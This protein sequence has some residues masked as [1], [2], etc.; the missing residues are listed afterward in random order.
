MNVI[1]KSSILGLAILSVLS[2]GCSSDDEDSDEYGNWV[3]SSSFDG[4]SRGNAASFT[5]G[6]KGYLVTGYDGDDY[7]SDTWEYNSEGDYWIQKADFPGTAR[8]GAV[9]F[10]IDGKGYI[11]TGYD[12]TDELKDFWEYNPDTNQ[13]TQK[14]D[15]A[16]TAR[17]GAIGFSVN[18]Y[19]YIGTG[20]DGSEQKDFYKYDASTD[21]WEQ[22]VGFGGQKRQNASVFVIDD[23]AYIG[24]GIHNGSVEY[25]FYSFDGT[26][27]TSLTD[28]DDDDDE[29]ITFTSSVAFSLNGKGYLTTGISGSITNVCWEYSPLSDTW[30]E[31][32]E[33]EGS[34]R[35]DAS[36]FS[37]DTKAFVL[38]GRSSNYYF[39]DVW[40]F[41]PDE[42]ENEDD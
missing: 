40:E 41:R 3:E 19:G 4:D 2:V 37:F 11:G 36:A 42:L 21:S 15:F 31:V 27:W 24:T 6:D 8:S 32:P 17:Y 33:F 26:T 20:Y 38:M 30:E 9:G 28:L 16:G 10:T 13:W 23:I 39:D 34:S 5:I 29:Y 18:G 35:K 1:K 12:G 14:A 7:L 25:D 22:V